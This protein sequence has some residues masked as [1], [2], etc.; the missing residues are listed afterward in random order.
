M[1]K[2]HADP[3]K[4]FGGGSPGHIAGIGLD[5]FICQNESFRVCDYID[6]TTKGL[7]FVLFCLNM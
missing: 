4:S 5:L 1:N 6:K 7:I 2:V 3:V